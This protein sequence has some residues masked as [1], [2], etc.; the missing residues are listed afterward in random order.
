MCNV[1]GGYLFVS[2]II[3]AHISELLTQLSINVECMAPMI[4]ISRPVENMMASPQGTSDFT[5]QSKA[6]TLPSAQQ[7]DG[8]PP[9]ILFTTDAINRLLTA[10]VVNRRFR[11]Q[12]LQNPGTAI[13]GGYHKESFVFSAA[14]L[15][16][17][18]AI[19]V[20]TLTEFAQ[21][22]YNLTAVKESA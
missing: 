12:L 19:R 7:E 5:L 4:Q 6:P 22:I 13:A 15:A 1:S 14:E 10:A 11:R 16:I 8:G 17:L 18:N 9:N 20:T 2:H 3:A 21:I